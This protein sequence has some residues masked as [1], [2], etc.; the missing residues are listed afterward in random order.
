MGNQKTKVTNKLNIT[1][2]QNKNHTDHIISH[3]P[4]RWRLTT[5]F[6][7]E[8]TYFQ[9]Q[10]YRSTSTKSGINTTTSQQQLHCRFYD[11]LKLQ[12]NNLIWSQASTTPIPEPLGSSGDEFTDITESTITTTTLSPEERWA[13]NNNRKAMPSSKSFKQKK[14]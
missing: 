7:S 1:D 2:D 13:L 12:L 10:S 9:C 4:E 11:N 8:I 5:I 14:N 3:S 6:K